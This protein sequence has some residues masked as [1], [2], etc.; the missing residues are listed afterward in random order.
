M[1]KYTFNATRLWIFLPT[2]IFL[3][4]F[5]PIQFNS[6][7]KGFNGVLGFIIF[8]VLLIVSF[9]FSWI[10]STNNISISMTDSNLRIDKSKGLLP[11]KSKDF[12]F[13][14]I[15]EYSFI[16]DRQYDTL[17]IKLKNGEIIRILKFDSLFNSKSEDFHRFVDRFKKKVDQLNDEKK[18][19]I[20]RVLNFYETKQGIYIAYIFG[21][22]ILLLVVSMIINTNKLNVAGILVAIAGGVF[23]I[24]Q[25]IKFKRKK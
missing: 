3:I 1:K 24:Y 21:F 5:F 11:Y 25:V 19:E 20:Y 7:F 2:L 23:Y 16:P 8:A 14:D 22:C 9:G 18:T 13:T 10:L 12:L 17:K 6:F 4:C 15:L